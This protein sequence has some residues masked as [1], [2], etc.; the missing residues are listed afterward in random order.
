[1]TTEEITEQPAA[2]RRLSLEE[3]KALLSQNIALYVGQGY[4]IE[5]QTDTM[6]SLI[7]GKRVNH[8]LHFFIGIF[9][10]GF[11]WIVWLIMAIAGGERRRMLTVDEYGNVLM[12][13]AGS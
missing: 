11:W 8:L 2:P 10:L 7:I 5:S 4:R 6:A 13:K 9:T 1:M 3:R 12:Q